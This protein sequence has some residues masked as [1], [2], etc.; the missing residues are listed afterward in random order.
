MPT[1]KFTNTS[2]FRV[3]Y[4]LRLTAFSSLILTTI[5]LAL[6]VYFV[7]R[8]AEV[9]LTPYRNTNLTLPSRLDLAYQDVSLTTQDSLNISGWY[10]AGTRPQAIILVHGIHA[11][12][13]AVLPEALILHDSGYHLLLIDL[14]G[15]GRSDEAQ[16]TYGYREAL[17]VQAAASYLASRPEIEQIGALGTSLGGAAVSRAAATDPHL[18]AVVIESSFSS[19]PAAVDD[20]F[21]DLSI[22]PKWPFAPLIIALA[23]QK[24]NLDI[25]EVDSARALATLSPRPVMIIHGNADE[26]FPLYHAEKMY[27]MAG[28]PKTL[29]VIEGMGH[30]NPVLA[31]EALYKKKVVTFFEQAFKR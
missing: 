25:A 29:W 18:E 19:L 5:F 9:F 13:M 12:R 16:L 11:N 31:N 24:A 7:N 10:I 17:D 28:E 21:D 30:S 15:H 1:A 26:L 6:L 4:W 23:E 8:Q 3:K 2:K 20:T 14:R 27:N 22:F